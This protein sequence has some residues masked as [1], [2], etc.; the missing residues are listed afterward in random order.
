MTNKN[1][2][3]FEFCRFSDE[4]ISKMLSVWMKL[5]ENEN[6]TYIST[7]FSLK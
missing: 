5:D 6:S 2:Q 7:M 4:F 3:I 1:V